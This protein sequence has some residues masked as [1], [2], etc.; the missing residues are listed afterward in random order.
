VD[1]YSSVE[2]DKKKKLEKELKQ[3]ERDLKKHGY[4]PVAYSELREAVR[5][6]LYNP[7]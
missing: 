5:D 2:E 7:Y 6:Y 3:I 4:F 1:D